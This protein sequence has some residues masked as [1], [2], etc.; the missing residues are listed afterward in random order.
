MC[1][2]KFNHMN[3]NSVQ[4][5]HRMVTSAPWD[6][7]T[8]SHSEVHGDSTTVERSA[9]VIPTAQPVCFSF[10]RPTSTAT[11]TSCPT[12]RSTT[13]SFVRWENF[14]SLLKYPLSPLLLLICGLRYLRRWVC[15]L[16]N[17]AYYGS[18]VHPNII[19]LLWPSAKSKSQELQFLVKGEMFHSITF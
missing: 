8:K 16:V 14:Y 1:V 2:Y 7:V 15:L 6:L 3:K 17:P 19:I 18:T 11:S 5:L 4:G 9:V 13:K 12:S 10:H